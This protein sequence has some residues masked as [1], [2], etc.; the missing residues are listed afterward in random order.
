MPDK[1]ISAL[2]GEVRDLTI[3]PALAPLL[4]PLA[5]W[6]TLPMILPPA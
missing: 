4:T 5:L 3:S 1:K 6:V 2:L